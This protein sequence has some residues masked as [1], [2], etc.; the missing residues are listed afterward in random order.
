MCL[1]HSLS[2]PI[3]RFP[4]ESDTFPFEKN[5]FFDSLLLSPTTGLILQKYPLPGGKEYS[6]IDTFSDPETTALNGLS[7]LPNPSFRS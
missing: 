1:C 7:C 5:A 4:E 2:D 6:M 3:F